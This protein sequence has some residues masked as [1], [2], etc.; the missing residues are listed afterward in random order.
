M[1]FFGNDSILGKNHYFEPTNLS[2]DKEQH[3]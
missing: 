2:Y 3:V 1:F